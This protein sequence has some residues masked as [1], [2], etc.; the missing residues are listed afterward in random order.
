MREGALEELAVFE[1]VVDRA[2]EAVKLHRGLSQSSCG[3][4]RT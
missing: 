3:R 1:A 4:L 2:L